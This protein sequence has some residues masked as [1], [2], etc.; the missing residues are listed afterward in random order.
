MNSPLPPGYPRGYERA[1]RLSDGRTVQLRPI[2]PDD[3]GQLAEAIRTADED[4]L[5]RRFVGGPP[6][7]TPELLT[8]LCTVDYRDRFALVATDPRTGR[9]VAIARYEAVPGD[10]A[11]VAVAVDRAWRGVGLATALV[12]LLAEAALDNGIHTFSA[13]FLAENRP[14]AALLDHIGGSGRRTIREG[15]AEAAVALDRDRV[16][17]AVDRL[18]GPQGP[19]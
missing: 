19:G 11:D 2:R 1:L 8:H 10:A 5:R 12:E 3:T 17:A 16:Q 18:E 14:V 7:V 4:T 15:F 9:G 6:H 13:Y